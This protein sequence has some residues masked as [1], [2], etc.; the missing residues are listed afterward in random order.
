MKVLN[1]RPQKFLIL[2]FIYLLSLPFSEAQIKTNE[3][4][5][6]E[7]I[8]LLNEILNSKQK[9]LYLFSYFIKQDAGLQLAISKDGFKWVELNNGKAIFKPTIGDGLLRDP[10]IIYDNKN[11]VFH[12]VWTTS[13]RNKGFG[14][15][16]SRDL[17]NWSDHHFISVQKGILDTPDLINAWAPEFF[18]DRKADEYMVIWAS[19]TDTTRVPGWNFQGINQQYYMRTKD[20]KAFSEPKLLFGSNLYGW[21]HID[22]YIRYAY[23]QYY[24]FAKFYSQVGEGKHNSIYWMKAPSLGGP[25]SY[26]MQQIPGTVGGK[27]EAPC[28]IKVGDKWLMYYDTP[29]GAAISEDLESWENITG[30]VEFPDK[31]RH[32]TAIEVKAHLLEP[33]LTHSLKQKK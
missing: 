30:Q 11:D 26:P 7:N 25:Y 4:E 9:N 19:A 12:L 1:Y 2:F 20:F 8:V 22:C 33:I 3:N 6:T 10:S 18:Y 31:W 17:L 32:G 16:S 21:L 29:K 14:Y 15:S 28:V 23:D 24:F 13:W 27:K 5:L